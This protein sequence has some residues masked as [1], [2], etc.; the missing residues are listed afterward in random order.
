MKN[1]LQQTNI[2]TS[3][4]S[5]CH[6]SFQCTTDSAPNHHSTWKRDTMNI[7]SI[8][9]SPLA[10]VSTYVSIY[11]GGSLAHSARLCDYRLKLY[12][13]K[14]VYFSRPTRTCLGMETA[15][16]KSLKPCRAH[17]MPRPRSI[18]I[19]PRSK[20]ST[21]LKERRHTGFHSRISPRLV[22]A[23]A[24]ISSISLSSTVR[25]HSSTI[26]IISHLIIHDLLTLL[27]TLLHPRPLL[28]RQRIPLI[29]EPRRLSSPIKEV[30]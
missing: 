4:F 11:K 22:R 15:R 14:E 23:T 12:Y 28:S 19:G 1:Q 18:E 20:R 29:L 21:H 7:K 13:T 26:V 17:V 10:N 2:H 5:R 16:L 25:I 8:I 6:P 9:R 30:D 27:S 24:S 3:H